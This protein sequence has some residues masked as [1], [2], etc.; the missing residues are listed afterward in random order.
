L[1]LKYVP[2]PNIIHSTLMH[3]FD[4][5]ER[6]MRLTYEFHNSVKNGIHPF[7]ITSNYMP[8]MGPANLENYLYATKIELSELKP[9]H[10][11]SNISNEVKLAIT[12]LKLNNSIVI[13]K[14]DKSNTTVILNRSDYIEEAKRQLNDGI[15][16]QQIVKLEIHIQ[17]LAPNRPQPMHTTHVPFTKITQN[18]KHN[19]LHG[20]SN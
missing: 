1:G 18:L 13:K 17:I 8:L 7:R 14:S 19:L 6:N 11:P 20:S 5:L 2:T 16:Y 12:N 10:I 15:H 3:D 4:N 9:M